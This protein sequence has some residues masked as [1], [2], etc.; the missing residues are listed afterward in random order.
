MP[1]GEARTVILRVRVTPAT[2]RAIAAV[3]TQKKQTVTEV[4]RASLTLGLAQI[5]SRTSL[6]DGGLRD[7]SSAAAPAQ[8]VAVA[9]VPDARPAGVPAVPR[10]VPAQDRRRIGAA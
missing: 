5:R 3:A 1:D 8:V 10:T 6:S 7:V 4:L 2:A 9:P